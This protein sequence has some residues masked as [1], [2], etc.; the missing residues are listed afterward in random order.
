M[1]G[2]SVLVLLLTVAVG[3]W[4]QYAIIRAAVYQGLLRFLTEASR[5]TDMRDGHD[6]PR[7]IDRLAAHLA[8][9]IRRPPDDGGPR[10]DPA[11]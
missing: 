9:V 2:V 7:R 1:D 11:D 10:R 5:V 3:L 8:E 6:V 4:V